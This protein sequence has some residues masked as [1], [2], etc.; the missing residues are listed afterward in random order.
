M[1]LHDASGLDEDAAGDHNTGVRRRE[2]MRPS[3]EGFEQALEIG[4]I[5][6]VGCRGGV[7]R[8]RLVIKIDE[9]IQMHKARVDLDGDAELASAA[10]LMTQS[11]AVATPDFVRRPGQVDGDGRAARLKRIH[12][13]QQRV[14]PEQWMETRKG[15]DSILQ[16]P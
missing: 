14:V 3:G 11:L 8:H 12:G 13:A 5:E 10:D 1:V 7:A 4:V 9:T 15:G 6:E 16:M 2:Q